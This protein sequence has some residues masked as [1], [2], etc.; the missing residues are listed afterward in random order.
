M[1]RRHSL[2]RPRASR[3]ALIVAAG[4]FAAPSL[5]ADLGGAKPEAAAPAADAAAQPSIATSL[6]PALATLG[7][8]RPWLSDRGVTFQLNYIGEVLGDVSGGMRRG[9]IYDGRLELV[10]DVDLEKAAGWKGGALHA[11]AYQIHGDGLSRDYVGNLL[12]VS[13]I[14]ALPTTR[15]YE[16]WF[17]QKFAGDKVAL[18][19]GQLGADTEFITSTYA[20]LFINGTF[21]WPG[22]TAVDLPSGGP[23]YPLATP[24]ARLALTPNANTTLLFGLFDGNPAGPGTNDPQQR[25]RYGLNFRLSD[26]PLA[27]AEGQLKYGAADGP[28]LPG[29]VKLGIWQHFG[30][31]DDLRTAADGTPLVTDGTPAQH[32]GDTGVYGVVDQQVWHLP[33]GDADKG[34]GVFAR[35]GFAPSNRNVVDFYLDTGL[36][37]NGVIASRPDDSFGIGFA[38][39]HISDAAHDFDVYNA[40]VARDYEAVIEATY[41]AQIVPGWSVQPNVQYIFH[42]GGHTANAYSPVGAPIKDALVVGVR[43]SIKY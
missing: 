10:I 20:G 15:L 1:S 27:I 11:N 18:R 6:P 34:L 36:N 5:A 37:F 41:Q 22:I 25:N 12:P 43:T 7:G 23:A 21:G 16:A 38:Y 9:A 29:T 33:G 24:G 28:V 31:F 42:P 8:L 32:R 17:E 14:E 39:A 30:K 3:L 35:A 19:I 2:H 26:A 40:N 4:L 13:N